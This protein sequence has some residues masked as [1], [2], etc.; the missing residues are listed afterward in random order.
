MD[1]K[2]QL[3]LERLAL[4][5]RR[6]YVDISRQR[7][8]ADDREISARMGVI[9]AALAAIDA[10]ERAEDARTAEAKRQHDEGLRAAIAAE[11]AV[12]RFT[13]EEEGAAAAKVNGQPSE[14]TA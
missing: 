2:V 14:V 13:P 10:D 8:A 6:E 11:H 1:T 5:S 3:Q 4:A 12:S 7:L 9:D